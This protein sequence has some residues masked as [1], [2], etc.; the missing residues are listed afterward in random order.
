MRPERPAGQAL[1][2]GSP[3]ADASC[4]DRRYSELLP[5]ML[6]AGA[7]ALVLG[8]MGLLTP[9]FTDFE[10]EA[11]PS[12]HSLRSGDWIAFLQHAPAYG[13][14]LVLRAPFAVLPG[15]WGGGLASW[16]APVLPPGSRCSSW[17]RTR[18]PCARSRSATRR[19]CSGAFCAS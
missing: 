5:P 16:D 11:E 3:E 14:S 7:C 4:M 13:G 17:R 2:R 12:L 8:A 6:V 9:A 1:K 19:S 10:L 18:S 15:L